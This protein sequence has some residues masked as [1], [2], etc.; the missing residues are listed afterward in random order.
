M[1][2]T[3]SFASVFIFFINGKYLKTMYLLDLQQLTHCT[4]I[5]RNK[6][7]MKLTR[8]LTSAKE[9]LDC[10]IVLI[11]IASDRMRLSGFLGALIPFMKA[12]VCLQM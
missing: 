4:R 12:G 11:S 1:I 6:N 2:P 3:I 5:E 8:L 9:S 7:C 10:I